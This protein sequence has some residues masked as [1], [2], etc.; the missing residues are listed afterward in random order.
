M[1][2][3]LIDEMVVF[4]WCVKQSVIEY[5]WQVGDVKIFFGVGLIV[6]CMVVEVEDKYQ[7]ICDL[8]MI[9]EVFV[10]FG[11]YFDYYDF[12]QY[13][14]DVLFL[15][16]GEFGCNSFCLI[17]DWIK[18]DVKCKGLLLCEIV[19][20]VVMLWLNFIGMVEYVVDELI[21]WYDVGVGDGFIFGFLVQV[22]GVDDF[23]E[24]VILV[25]EVCGCYSCDLFGVILCDYFGLLCKVS[26]YVVFGVVQEVVVE[27]YV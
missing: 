13:L 22:Q 10:Y 9:D 18:V 25:F 8:L 15:E 14:F 11:C 3:L 24:F 20:V 6:G 5:G 23:I 27:V 4:M 12:M 2:L 17:I 21:C 16:F 1:Y 26:C 7:V 19:F